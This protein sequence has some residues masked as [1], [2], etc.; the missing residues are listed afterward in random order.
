MYKKALAGEIADFTGINA[1]YEVPENADI[2]LD[3]SH[4]ALDEC[5]ELI[6]RTVRRGEV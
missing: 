5:V 1:P 2:V 3:T 6:L 4:I